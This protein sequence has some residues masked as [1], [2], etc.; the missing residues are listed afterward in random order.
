MDIDSLC[1]FLSIT[2]TSISCIQRTAGWLLQLRVY[3]L[4]DNKNLAYPNSSPVFTILLLYTVGCYISSVGN[5]CRNQVFSLF[6]FCLS[7]LLSSVHTDWYLWAASCFVRFPSHVITNIY[8]ILSLFL[9]LCQYERFTNFWIVGI[10]F[11]PTSLLP[12]LS[13]HLTFFMRKFSKIW[14]MD[15]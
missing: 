14:F 10:G 1:Q 11:K 6:L 8:Y 3:N 9:N 4:Q 15:L 7:S 13:F 5:E 2:P 12:K